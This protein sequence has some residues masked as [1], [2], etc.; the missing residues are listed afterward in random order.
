[1]RILK[2]RVTTKLAIS[3]AFMRI[4][5]DLDNTIIFY[6]NAFVHAA[7]E[8]GL[9][10][11]D[12]KG[13]KQQVRD[14]I[15]LLENGETEWQKLQGYVY[16]KGLGNAALFAGLEDFLK[17][18][19]Q[20][21]AE[22]FIVSH[23]TEFGH[24]DPERVNLR[25]AA[26]AWLK[27][28][29]ILSLVAEK[30]IHFA[31]TRKEKVDIIAG[32]GPDWFIDDLVEVYEEPHFPPQV[33][34]VLFHTAPETPPQG[35]WTVCRHWRDID[36]IVT[37][38]RVAENLLKAPIASIEHAAG[39]GNS[40]IYK[41]VAGGK[42]YA[43]KRYPIIEGDTRDR[44][45]TE[46][47]ALQL[48]E[49]NNTL[50]VP[51]LVRHSLGEGG[52][53]TSE[54]PFA[55]ME[56]IDGQAVTTP[57]EKDIDQA[58]AF[59][60]KLFSINDPSMPPASEACLSGTEIVRQLEARLARLQAV[61]DAALASFLKDTFLPAMQSRIARARTYKDFDKELPAVSRRLI[62]ADFGFHNALRAQN[63][64]LVFIDFEYLGWDD[65]VKLIA[66]FLLHPAMAL[67]P[68]LRKRFHAPMLKA[69][70]PE[71]EGRFS[72]FY[73]LF[74]LRWT[75]ILLN[76]FLPERWQARKD[77][78]GDSDLETA[79]RRQLEKAQAML[80]DSEAFK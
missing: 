71:A 4:G 26:R 3:M 43:L 58:T 34:K 65:P 66:D 61:E 30:N 33:K 36:N 56:W 19:K 50:C 72:A 32:L 20:A 51:R 7:I 40:R 60:T 25:D 48:F 41:V 23:K 8:R 45:N 18:V 11:A 2:A 17:S 22:L 44:L 59:L 6:D 54:S 63:G 14:A 74:G 31:E 28:R 53:I 64:N 80:T 12:F 73:P 42:T 46:R 10:P 27:E 62:A 69:L 77:A 75:L 79:K 1:M 49:K 38:A 39:G 29:G 35:S 16:G 68:A 13:T 67:S 37:G 52:W 55:L 76:E 15:R 78:R 70:E 5:I 57:S 24:Y 47:L 21:G 9:L